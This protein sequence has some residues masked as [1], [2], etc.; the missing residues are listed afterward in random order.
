MKDGTDKPKALIYCR[1]SSARQVREGHGLESQET[2][3]REYSDRMGYE[4]VDVFHDQGVQGAIVDRPAMQLMLAFLRRHSR[5][6]QF[7]VIIDDISR[8]AR[9]LEAHLK[10][11]SAIVTAG[12]RLESP[13]VEFGSDSDSILVENLLAS[14][15][16][17]QRQKNAEQVVNRMRARVMNGYWV[18]SPP[19]GYLYEKVAGHGKMLV[20]DEPDASIV[21][22]ALDGY[23]AGRFGNVSEVQ[24][25]L[26]SDTGFSR[27]GKRGINFNFVKEMLERPLYAGYIDVPK[28]GIKLHPGKHEAVITFDTWL[29]I[30]QRLVDKAPALAR[31]DLNEDFPLRGFVVCGCCNKPMTAAWA[32]GRSA[33]YPYYWCRTD[34]C[35]ESGRSIRRN[36]IEQEFEDLLQELRPSEDLFHLLGDML[37]EAWKERQATTKRAVADIRSEITQIERKIEQLVERILA[38]DSPALVAAYEKEVRKMEE[39]RIAL[40]ERAKSGTRPTKTFDEA[41]RTAWDFLEN[42]GKLWASGR[43][44]DRRIV[45]QLTF[46]GRAPYDRYQGFRTAIPTLPFS[47]LAGISAGDSGLVEPGGIEPPTS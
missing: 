15:S 32:R 44:V 36:V 39:R 29:R 28:W 13:S 5:G 37:G 10:L 18:F 26:R 45:L 47:I 46:G 2:R 11:R 27:G 31:K 40:S 19:A 22:E 3:C 38:A 25:F 35:P 8:L 7:V 16:Q 9:G 14:V 17:H 43:L 42:P 6:D 34:G 30:Q 24:R 12:G 20:R 1:V 4:I 23:A 21:C 33:E 41:V